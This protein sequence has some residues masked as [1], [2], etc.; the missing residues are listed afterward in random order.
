MGEFWNEELETMPWEEVQRYW[1]GVLSRQLQY[2]KEASPFYRERLKNFQPER[3][4]SLEQMRELPFL[5]K[6]DVR[7]AQSA[8]DRDMPLGSLQTARTEDIVQVLSSSGTS[9][10]PV[11]Y[12]LTRKDLEAFRDGLAMFFY[13]AGVRKEDIVAHTTAVPLFAGGDPYFEGIRH[14]GATTVWIGGVS[15]TR[16][17]EIMRYTH[18]NVL[19]ATAS[20]DVY[21]GEHCLEAL[22]VEASRLGIVKVLGGGEPGLGEEPIRRKLKELWG[23]PTVREIMGLADV[24]PGVWAE[25]E[26]ESGM[27]FVA[28]R[29]VAVELIDPQSGEHLPWEPGVTGEPV[30][31]AL[32]R[33]AT[34]AVRYRSADLIRVEGVGCACGRHSPRIRCIG[35]I[36][37]MLIYKAMNVFPSAI[38]DVIL[39]HFG[40]AVTGYIQVVKDYPGQVR[41]DHPIPVDVEVKSPAQDLAAL[42]RSMED[43]VRDL[44][45]V[46]IEATLVAPNTLPRT[47]YKTA[48]VRVRS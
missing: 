8:A 19:Q 27:H 21:L 44:L 10:R 23:E 39:N 12:G 38:R 41:F 25:C 37:D 3:L 46:R 42:K 26:Q 1:L 18:C 22:G 34:P 5:T 30:Y 40:D 47:Q 45:N 9:G 28:L 2:V 36:D 16:V 4:R 15:T 32:R 6:E 11:F 43:K 20:F 14:I 13:T 33:E 7:S 48:L 35:R 17:L 24:F 31:T 29:D